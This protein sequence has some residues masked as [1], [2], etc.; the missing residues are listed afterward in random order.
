MDPIAFKS[1]D[2]GSV[3]KTP[4]GYWAFY[5]NPL[6][7]QIDLPPEIVRLLDEATGAVHRLGGVGRLLPN[8]HLLISPYL[9]IE[10]LLSS[11]IEGTRSD[12]TK[13]LRHEAGERSK[14]ARQSDD[15]AEVANY[16]TALEHGIR[17]LQD[18]VPVSMRL[19]REMHE[20][21]LTGVRGRQRRPG[22]LR[23]SPVWIGGPTLENAAFVP[24]PPAEARDAL[25]DLEEFLHSRDM[26]LLV[27]LALAHYQFEVIHPFLEGNGRVGRL[28]I[29]VM[30]A[31]RGVLP[32]PLLYFSAF[33]ERHRSLYYDLLMSTSQTGDLLP[34]LAFFLEGARDQAL[35]S[36]QSTVRLVEFQKRLRD[37]LLGERRSGSVVR[38][39]ELLMAISMVTAGQ[40][41]K[42]LGVSRTTAHH[43][44]NVLVDRGTLRE[45]TG[46]ARGQIYAAPEILK[47]VYRD[48]G[49]L[50]S[51]Y[52]ED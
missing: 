11:R 23:Q 43:S 15:D 17:R 34:W 32:Q 21:L 31:Y 7:R 47:A 27:L 13:L 45:V 5:P 16:V 26:P 10:A 37:E 36:E 19:L 44:I 49:V 35:E 39:A 46:R 6:P 51:E 30:L 28:M 42:L 14:D 22:E 1:A 4:A 18:G 48:V 52:T 2:R 29:P 24:P 9:R 33:F 38:L 3:R 20:K 50:D 40:V 8:P 41:A 25:G 12:V